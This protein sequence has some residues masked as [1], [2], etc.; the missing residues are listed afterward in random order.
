VSLAD[1]LAERGEIAAGRVYLPRRALKVEAPVDTAVL[2]DQDVHLAF[3]LAHAR[4]MDAASGNAVD[5]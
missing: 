3:D 2:P 1:R 5:A 4:W